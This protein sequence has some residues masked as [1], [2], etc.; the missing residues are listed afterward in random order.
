M[1]FDV[2]CFEIVVVMMLLILD[3]CGDDA[4]NFL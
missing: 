4:V 1:L 3:C 2:V